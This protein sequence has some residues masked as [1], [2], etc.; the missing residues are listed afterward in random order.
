MTMWAQESAYFQSLTRDDKNQYRS[1][2]TLTDGKTLPDPNNLKDWK[3]DVSLL[4]DIGMAD[5]YMYLIHTPS[6]FTHD[7]L[8]CYKS[9]DAYNSFLNGHVQD[10]YYHEIERNSD[11]AFIKSEVRLKDN[12]L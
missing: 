1:K 11:Y 7:S 2:L 9:L 12:H 3:D 5:V 6:Q 10:V 8:K 4:P